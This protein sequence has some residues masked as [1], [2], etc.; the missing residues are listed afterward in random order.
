MDYKKLSGEK[1]TKPKERRKQPTKDHDD[2]I[3]DKRSG[4]GDTAKEHDPR[5]TRS[6]E[7]RNTGNT[8]RDDQNEEAIMKLK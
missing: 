5:W 8:E 4:R 3:S 6:I 2:Q 7:K 1:N